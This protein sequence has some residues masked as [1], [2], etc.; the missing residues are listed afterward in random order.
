MK[1]SRSTRSFKALSLL[2]TYVCGIPLG[3]FEPFFL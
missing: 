2:W 3:D 1:A